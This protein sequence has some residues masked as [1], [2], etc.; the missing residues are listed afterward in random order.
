M[1]RSLLGGLLALLGAALAYGGL[2]RAGWRR[3]GAAA[4]DLS[5]LHLDWL[6]SPGRPGWGAHVG[7]LTALAVGVIALAVGLWFLGSRRFRP[8]EGA[9]RGAGRSGAAQGTSVQEPPEIIV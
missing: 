6:G 1:R 9:P 2:V 5:F 7:N 3:H 8:V 4:T